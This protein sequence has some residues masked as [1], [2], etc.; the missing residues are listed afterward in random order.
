MVV[1][2]HNPGD[3]D[4][5]HAEQ[6]HLQGTQTDSSIYLSNYL[7]IHVFIYIT[8]Q[9]HLQSTQLNS[10]IYLSNY[11]SIYP[12]IYLYSSTTPSP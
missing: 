5:R 4:T 2:R 1:G 8:Q 12:C 6:H 3:L 7:S 11:L 10:S 9:N